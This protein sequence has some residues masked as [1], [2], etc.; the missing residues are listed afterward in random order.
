MTQTRLVSAIIVKPQF[1][2]CNMHHGPC[3]KT[4]DKIVW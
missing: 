4:K 1:A 3:A 2:P